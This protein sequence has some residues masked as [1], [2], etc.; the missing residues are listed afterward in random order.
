M[1]RK[2]FSAHNAKVLNEKAEVTIRD[3]ADGKLHS[4]LN[5]AYRFLYVKS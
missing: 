3:L 1:R 5:I 2:G 4:F